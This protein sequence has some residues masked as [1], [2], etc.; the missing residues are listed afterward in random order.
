MIEE[1]VRRVFNLRNLVHTAH[2]KTGSYAQ[3]VALGSFYEALPSILDNIVEVYQGCYGLIKVP[4]M[5]A[6][7]VVGD[8]IAKIKEDAEWIA[9]NRSSIA[10]SNPMIENLID[11]LTA[12][13][14][15]TVYKLENLK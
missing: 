9:K 2:W 3:H 12:E 13:F 8:I 1:L 15:Q 4:A 10:K 6:A 11:G 14:Y 7:P 5:A